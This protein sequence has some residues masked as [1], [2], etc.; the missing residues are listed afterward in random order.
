MTTSVA[1][2]VAGISL[3]VATVGREAPLIT[4][5]NSLVGQTIQDFELI[6]VDQNDDMRL[7]PIV[8]QARRGGLQVKHLQLKQRNLSHARNIGLAEARCEIVGFPD[9][10]CWYERDAM[11]QVSGAFASDTALDGLV[12]RW[13]EHPGMR[14][15]AA[16]LASYRMRRFRELPT[17]SISLFFRRHLLRQVGAFDVELGVGR[18]YGGGEEI[19]LMLRCLGAG[20]RVAYFPQVRVHHHFGVVRRMTLAAARRR[21]RGTGALYAK[22]RLDWSVVAR[23]LLAP[24]VRGVLRLHRPRDC[25]NQ[26]ATALGRAEGYVSWCR[27]R[28]RGSGSA[29]L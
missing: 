28:V 4:L 13:V 21:A 9:D 5:V 12:A 19:D 23:G 1:Q 24:L 2:N 11:A 8:S 18:W 25:A 14:P 7:V 10:D 22:H 6:V 26:F 3:I 29:V 16:V 15:S 17:S 20:A 27:N